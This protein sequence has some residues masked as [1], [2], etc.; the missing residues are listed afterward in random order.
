MND[1][2]RVAL[3]RCHAIDRSAWE[4]RHVTAMYSASRVE[5]EADL[6]VLGDRAA[7]GWRDLNEISGGT[8]RDQNGSSRSRQ[9]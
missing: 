8:A 7:V 5:D 4:P 3:E 6:G 2:L 1:E 9:A